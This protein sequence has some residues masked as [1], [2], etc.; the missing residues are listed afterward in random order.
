[1]FGL[2]KLRK[3]NEW[4]EFLSDIREGMILTKLII[5]FLYNENINFHF[6][7]VLGD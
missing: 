6:F 2:R 5:F 3:R 1:V 7:F 4:T